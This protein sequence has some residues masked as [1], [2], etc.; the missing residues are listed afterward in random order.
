MPR[1]LNWAQDG[2]DWPHRGHSE[3][4]LADGL[5]WH[6]QRFECCAASVTTPPWLVL[7]HGTGASTHSWRDLIPLLWAHY[8][9]L[10]MDLPG[11]AF[12]D[13]PS[14]SS[15][16][17]QLS[18]P[19]MAHALAALLSQLAVLPS[20]VVGHS[21]GAALAVEMAA[22]GAAV[23]RRI[24]SLNG[25]LLPLPGLVG[26]LFSPVAKLMAATPWVPKLFSWHAGDARVLNKLI[27]AT[28]S[29]LDPQGLA[30]YGKL[31]GN[32]GH[33]AGALA[34]MA[35]WDLPHAARQLA[36]L[37]IPLHLVVGLEDRTISPREAHRVWAMLPDASRRPIQEV[38]GLGHLAH[39][40]RPDLLAA[41]LLD[42]LDTER[43]MP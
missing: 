15:S 9:V 38:P 24:F 23:P 40:E 27:N 25:A 19:G 17:P 35:N 16:S 8:S 1:R 28:G 18:L 32:P 13:M 12:T 22:T 43:H 33:A 10:A 36:R 6:V 2:Q 7:I 4:V 30:L 41:L 39:E 42:G 34:M 11:H 20:V 26:P 14:Q 21:A 5:R 3:F 29:R 31:V 37:P